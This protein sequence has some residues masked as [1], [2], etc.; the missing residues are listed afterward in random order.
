MNTEPDTIIDA[1]SAFDA[2]VQQVDPQ[3]WQA[4]TACA[5][6]TAR[7]VAGHVSFV[8][9]LIEGMAKGISAGTPDGQ[10]PLHNASKIGNTSEQLFWNMDVLQGRPFPLLG[11]DDDPKAL[12]NDCRTA[13]LAAIDEPANLKHRLFSPWKEVVVGEY[14][15][16]VSF[17]FVIHTWDLASA[18]GLDPAIDPALVEAVMPYYLEWH[19]MAMRIPADD[20]VNGIRPADAVHTERTDP[21]SRLIAMSGRDP[22]F[23]RS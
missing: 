6:W 20:D 5:A 2:I 22:E 15:E 8:A 19:D 17:D 18:V 12:W 16:W 21:L 14:V 4:P 1:V 13:M 7:D 9:V 10:G 23:G 3:N 11:P